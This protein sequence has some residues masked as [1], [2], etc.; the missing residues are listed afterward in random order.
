MKTST[1]LPPRALEAMVS[2]KLAQAYR[3]ADLLTE[4]LSTLIKDILA[5]QQELAQERLAQQQV[6][7]SASEVV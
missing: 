2:R 4:L 5:M 6:Q 7:V 3:Q 1:T